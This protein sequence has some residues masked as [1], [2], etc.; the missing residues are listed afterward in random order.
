MASVYRCWVPLAASMVLSACATA[1]FDSTWMAP[2]ARP[3]QLRGAKVAA[4]VMAKDDTLRRAA[5]D[6]LA[7]EITAR[8]AEGMAMYKLFPDFAGDEAAARTR[9][10]QAG[11]SGAV[12]MRPLA[13]EK[14]VTVTPVMYTDPMHRGFWGGYYSEGWGN[15]WGPTGGEVHT[16]SVV[17]VETLVYSLAQNKLVWGGQ[18]RSTNP[19]DVDQLVGEVAA[20]AAKELEER[21]LI[22]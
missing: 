6:K 5:E 1:V 11:V 22:R 19:K 7:K 10:E 2:D 21:G 12:V 4:V 8:G 13:V 20:A 18:S 15:A 14:E 9:L 3:L 17:V 16:D